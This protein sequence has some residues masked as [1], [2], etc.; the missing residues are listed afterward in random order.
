MADYEEILKGLN[1]IKGNL[2]L[3][4][5]CAYSDENGHGWY[6]CKAFCAKDAIELLKDQRE[7]IEKL[8]TQLDEAML[9]R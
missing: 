7:T 6:H 8:R 1:C 5:D 4:V 9:W 3:C 2:G